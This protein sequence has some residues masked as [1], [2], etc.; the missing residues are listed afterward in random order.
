MKKSLLILG[1]VLV[2]A[3]AANAQI[4]ESSLCAQP[5]YPISNKASQFFSKYTGTNFVVSN[6]AEYQ[7]TRLF[8]KMLGSDLK[9]NFKLYSTGDFADGKFKSMQANANKLVLN[10]ISIS[11]FQANTVCDFN[12]IMP[13]DNSVLFPENFVLE[14]NSK[15]TAED[16][17]TIINAQNLSDFDLSIGR[18]TVF[19]VLSTQATIVN[20]RINIKSK[21]IHPF[22][23]N[24]VPTEISVD[25]GLKAENGNIVYSDVKFNSTDSKI[26]LNS[27]L[28]LLNKFK[29]LEQKVEIFKGTFATVKVKDIS[30]I[31]NKININ[32]VTVIPKNY[33]RTR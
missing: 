15:M 31:D 25:T 19:K 30:I 24:R 8:R 6:L 27:I 33:S 3:T 1:L 20:N 28:P 13:R 16:L 9:M 7:M 21:L 17:Q 12:Y 11:E 22:S 26:G 2:S 18:L 10:G 23:F 4:E 29:P 5:P 32:G 14:F